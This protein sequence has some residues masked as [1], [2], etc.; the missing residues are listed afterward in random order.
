MEKNKHKLLII[1]LL[2]LSISL[3]AF[4][5]YDKFIDKNDDSQKESQNNKGASYYT[6]D[7]LASK[8]INIADNNSYIVFETQTGRWTANRN[9]CDSYNEIYGTFTVENDQV[10]LRYIDG[11]TT[12]FDIIS[13]S[14]FSKNIELLHDNLSKESNNASCIASTY[15]VKEK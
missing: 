4:I 1:I 10:V 5:I 3:G 6:K 7:S 2:I 14:D 8:Y 12:S 15:F 13:D 9:F 11:T